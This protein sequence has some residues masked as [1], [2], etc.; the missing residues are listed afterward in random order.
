MGPEGGTEEAK[1]TPDSGS[2]ELSSFF[3][4][5]EEQASGGAGTSAPGRPPAAPVQAPI[6]RLNPNLRKPRG[7]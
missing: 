4:I 3:A 6:E 5:G 7:R 2:P 1:A